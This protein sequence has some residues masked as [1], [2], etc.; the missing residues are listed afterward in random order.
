VALRLGRWSY[1]T[2]LFHFAAISLACYFIAPNNKH[3]AYLL[4]AVVAVP[5]TLLISWASY[6]WIERPGI[7][8]GRWLFGQR[9]PIAAE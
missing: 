2:Y 6:C 8:M 7:A 9:R 5:L 1:S 3:E 4:F